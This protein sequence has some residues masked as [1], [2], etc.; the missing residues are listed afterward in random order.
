MESENRDKEKKER[1]KDR[2]REKIIKERR[3]EALNYNQ[4]EM[5][6]T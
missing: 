2:K 5:V 6:K 1:E 3:E 4:E